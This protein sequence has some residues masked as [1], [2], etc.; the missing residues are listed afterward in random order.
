M[1]RIIESDEGD[2]LEE[3]D[4]EFWGDQSHSWAAWIVIDK[5]GLHIEDYK[6][7]EV[8]VKPSTWTHIAF[9]KTEP[10]PC[11]I[12][13]YMDGIEYKGK[14]RYRFTL[15]WMKVRGVRIYL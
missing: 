2:E 6:E 13:L 14:W 4:D 1:S 10:G 15:W 11:A 9:T 8:P 5:D 3:S 7:I 12:Q